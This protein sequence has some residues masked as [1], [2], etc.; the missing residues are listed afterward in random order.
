[1]VSTQPEPTLCFHHSHKL[2][3]HVIW[4]EEEIIANKAKTET[5]TFSIFKSLTLFMFA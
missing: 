4:E 2:Q 5:Q 3:H 1:M